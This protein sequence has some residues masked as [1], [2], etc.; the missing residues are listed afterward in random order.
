[1]NTFVSSRPAESG[2][3]HVSGGLVAGIIGKPRRRSAPAPSHTAASALWLAGTSWLDAVSQH[4]GFFKR[5]RHL[6]RLEFLD[7]EIEVVAGLGAPGRTLSRRLD[8]M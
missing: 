8:P 1:M 7:G 2:T 3:H 6:H 5:G 4:P